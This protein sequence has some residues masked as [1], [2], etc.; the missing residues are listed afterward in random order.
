MSIDAA[1]P[2]DVG[3]APTGTSPAPEALEDS[4]PHPSDPS[5][6]PFLLFEGDAGAAMDAYLTAFVEHLPVTEVRRD[7]FDDSSP[8][9]AEWAGK[10]LHGELEI[11]GQ[12]L[13][14]FDSFTPHGFTF[15]PAISLFV[16]LPDAT[17]VDAVHDALLAGGGRDY[18]PPDDYGFSRRFAWVGDRFGVTWQLNAA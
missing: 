13:R 18:M 1:P 11:A 9:G 17:A 7:L 2:E 14:F 16:E 6:T 5:V 12:R 8:R 4:L 10:V 15:T 3:T